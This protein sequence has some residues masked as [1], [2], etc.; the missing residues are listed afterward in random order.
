MHSSN[1]HPYRPLFMISDSGDPSSSELDVRIACGVLIAISAIQIATG[2]Q[3]VVGALGVAGG[4][5]GLFSTWRARWT[6]S[7]SSC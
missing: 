5:A 2:A 3:A 6:M 7:S 4:L 1:E